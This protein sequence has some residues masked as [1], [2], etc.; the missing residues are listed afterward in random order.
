MRNFEKSQAFRNVDFGKPN[1]PLRQSAGYYMQKKYYFMLN[2][3]DVTS[4]DFSQLATMYKQYSDPNIER[5]F[6]DNGYNV[7]DQY[8][9]VEKAFNQRLNGR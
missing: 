5:F 8:K 6:Y 2:A 9:Q 1:N 3:L 7:P 4:S